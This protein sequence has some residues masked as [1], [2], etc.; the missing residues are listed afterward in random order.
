ML[1]S[2]HVH[3]PATH[4]R[5]THVGSAHMHRASAHMWSGHMHASTTHV[6][7]TTAHVHAATATEVAATSSEVT[8]ATTVSTASP[9]TATA[10]TGECQTRSSTQHQ[11]SKSPTKNEVL[12]HHHDLPSF[13][14]VLCA[15]RPN[16][17]K[18][19]SERWQIFATGIIAGRGESGV[20]VL[21]RTHLSYLK[22]T[23]Q[24]SS[25]W[26]KKRNLLIKTTDRFLRRE[27]I[28]H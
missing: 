13:S 2:T 25:S 18:R 9:M 5:A 8:T 22:S 24:R 20:S 26:I 14:R 11:E 17:R 28:E 12:R 19:T 7:S 6:H 3:R 23:Y 4:S 15:G 27:L 21:S 16:D 10:A 1:S